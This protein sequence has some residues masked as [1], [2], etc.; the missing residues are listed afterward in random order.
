MYNVIITVP[1]TE[2]SEGTLIQ[3]SNYKTI[4][5]VTLG[6]PSTIPHA[7]NSTDLSNKIMI[8]RETDDT[9]DVISALSEFTE[10][11]IAVSEVE[12]PE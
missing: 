2:D 6:L 3:N 4:V 1:K 10:A 5:G 12:I 8:Q 7:F 11:T 9:V